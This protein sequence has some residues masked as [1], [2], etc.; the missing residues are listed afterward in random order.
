VCRTPQRNH[1][2]D[3]AGIWLAKD[4]QSAALDYLNRSIEYRLL[5]A[6]NFEFVAIGIFEEEGVVTWTVVLAHLR[7]LKIF[8][9]SL[10]HQFR[11]P[12]HFFARVRPKRYACSVRF[13]FLISAKTKEFRRFP[14][15]ARIERM[16]S[17]RFLVNESKLW[18]KFTVK[19]FCNFHVCHPQIDVIEA[20]RFHV[21]ILNCMARHFNA[22]DRK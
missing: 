18:Q 16:I 20:T 7:A 4:D 6:A 13:M 8:P 2:N 3:E 5:A 21:S 11:N 12:I 14:A 17:P 19:L 10:A 15:P 1:G 22:S 9:A